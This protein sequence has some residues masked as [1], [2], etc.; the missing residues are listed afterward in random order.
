MSKYYLIVNP[1]SGFKRGLT[2]LEKVKPIAEYLS[3]KPVGEIL[4]QRGLFPSVH[5]DVDNQLEGDHPWKWIGWDYIY[6]NDIGALIKHTT[7]VFEDSMNA[8]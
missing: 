4:A 1:H 3:S 8:A 2:I 5:P 7:K 6:Q